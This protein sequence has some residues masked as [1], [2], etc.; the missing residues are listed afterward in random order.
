MVGSA[1]PDRS[2]FHTRAVIEAAV[3]QRDLSNC[4]KLH[5]LM[6]CLAVFCESFF[7]GL[8]ARSF[9]NVIYISEIIPVKCLRDTYFAGQTFSQEVQ[10]S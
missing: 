2:Q 4:R 7:P 6:E 1:D 9:P 5:C 10:M 3:N 8:Q